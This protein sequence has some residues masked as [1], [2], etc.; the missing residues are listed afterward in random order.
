[1][2]DVK[3]KNKK[4]GEKILHVDFSE[5]PDLTVGDVVEIMDFLANEYP[6]REI[7]IDGDE[8][9]ICSRPRKPSSDS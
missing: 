9:G 3:F 8:N 5:N 6:D 1:M 7:F 2:I 4:I